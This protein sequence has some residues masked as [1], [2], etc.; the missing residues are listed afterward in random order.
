MSHQNPAIVS[1]AD[2]NAVPAGTVMTEAFAGV[3]AQDVYVWGWPIVN[4]FHRRASFTTAPEPGLVGG[5]LPAAPLGFVAMLSHYIDPAQRWVAHPNQDVVYGFGYGAVDSDPVVLQVP[6]FGDR[7]WVCA[8]YDAR[9]DEFSNLGQQYGTE[10]GNYLVVGPTWEGEV[11]Q[12]ITDILRSPTDL[13]AIGP[14]LF[15]N[16]TDADR[17]AI[18]STLNQVVVYPLSSYTGESKTVDWTAIPHFPSAKSGSAETR[19]V[20][21]ETFFDELPDILDQVPALP[22]EEARYAM[23]LALLA[24]AAAD[25]AIATAVRTAAIDAEDTIIAPLFEFHTNGIRLPS[26]WNSPPNVARWGFDYLTRTATAKSNMYVNQPEETRYFFLEVDSHGERLT[27]EHGY[28]ITF[29]PGKLPPVNGFWSL[30]LYNP[31]HFFAPNDLGRYS[32]GTK[33]TSMKTADDGSLTIHIQ[34]HSPGADREPNWLPA[35]DGNFELTIRTYWP[36]PEVNQGNWT[37]PPVD[38]TR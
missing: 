30:T 17:A 13:V 8:L 5:V 9:S 27:G 2:L 35:P 7:F 36:K 25:T 34:Q 32:L 10:P 11:P 23:M 33:N 15:L 22:G 31:Q 4:A 24:A 26:G 20:D 29:P 6:D 19:W 18:R 14:R 3:L 21:P 38:R 1:A 16:D 12:G 28:T 37:P